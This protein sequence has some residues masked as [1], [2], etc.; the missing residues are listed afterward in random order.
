MREELV[1]IV[2]PVYNQEKYLNISIPSIQR[3]KHTNLEIILVDDGSTDESPLIL[4]KYKQADKRIKI[5]KKENGGLVDATIAGVKNATGEYVVFL[6]PDDY[7]GETFIS[8]LYVAMDADCDFVASGFFYDDKGVHSPYYL[9][10]NRIYEREQL[11]KLMG[12][13][14]CDNCSATVSNEIFISRWNKLYRRECLMKVIEEFSRCKQI[15]LGEDTIFTFFVLKYSRKGKTLADVNDYFYNVGNQNSMMKNGTIDKHLQKAYVA[16][17]IYQELLL[18]ANISDI[19]AYVLYYYLVNALFRRALLE[20]KKTFD[21]L[22]KTLYKN[23]IYQKALNIL[24][25]RSH[26]KR[27]LIGLVLNKFVCFPSVY[28]FILQHGIN[29]IKNIKLF[30][31]DFRFLL[32]SIKKQG[33]KK[34]R[35]AYKFRKNRRKAFKD[36]KKEMPIIEKRIESI[37]HPYTNM[38]TNIGNSTIENNVFVFWWDG[39]ENAPEIVQC[40]F[41]SVEKWHSESNVIMIAKNNYQQYTDINPV[42]IADYEAGKISVQT[43][44]DI[45]RFNLLKNNGGT[46]I[47]STIFFAGNFDLTSSLV[48]KSFESVEFSTSKN[49][50]RYKGEHCSWSGYFICSRKNGVLVRV[51]D[52]IFEEYYLTYHTYSIYFFIDA[53]LMVCKLNKIDDNVLSKTRKHMGDMAELIGLLDVPYDKKYMRRIETLPQ[54]LAWNYVPKEGNEH[55]MYSRV[56]KQYM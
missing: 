33:I 8:N 9:K 26:K 44:S 53:A 55:T 25:K 43:F 52:K 18:D 47:D 36:L 21:C 3:Q 56:V 41:A 29:G 45:L 13:Y 31:E 38:K 40:C 20:N 24:I 54:K 30:A 12:E 2:V 4:E 50:L 17:R 49:Y 23:K 48:D 51:M 16:F 37:I 46:W 11:D 22:Y 42:I 15:T 28:R 35:Y 27:Q 14:L 1:S 10:E 19:Q 32:L 6:D 39:L 5:I 34:T 7:I